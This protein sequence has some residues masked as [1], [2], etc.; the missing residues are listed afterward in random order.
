[1]N[2][3]K[4]ALSFEEATDHMEKV[5]GLGKYQAPPLTKEEKAEKQK[6]R[7]PRLPYHSMDMGEYEGEDDGW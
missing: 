3:Y 5:L 4:K 6:N 1:M 7:K 2:W